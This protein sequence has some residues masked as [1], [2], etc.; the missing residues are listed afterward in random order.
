MRRGPKPFA[1]LVPLVWIDLDGQEPGAA[2]IGLV[3]VVPTQTS[4]GPRRQTLQHIADVPEFFGT[5]RAAATGQPVQRRA[6][7][8]Q[9]QD[10]DVLDAERLIVQLALEGEDLLALVL[11]HGRGW[12]A[13]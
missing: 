6:V 1:F 10:Q 2:T 3:E 4:G 9:R 5:S 8:W 7:P 13:R 11:A 12:M